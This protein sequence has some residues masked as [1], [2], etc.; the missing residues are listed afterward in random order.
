MNDQ[1]GAR[2]S[3]VLDGG[4]VAEADEG[5]AAEA[6]ARERRARER[7]ARALEHARVDLQQAKESSDPEL[8]AA[9]R[10]SA[11]THARAAKLHHAAAVL[12]ARHAEEHEYRASTSNGG[13]VRV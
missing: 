13:R 8:A 1:N 11:S 2:D 4:L 9:Y 7:E 12:Q 5:I 6:H 3:P 10:R